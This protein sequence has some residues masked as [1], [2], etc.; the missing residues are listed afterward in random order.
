MATKVKQRRKVFST[1]HLGIRMTQ[2]IKERIRKRIKRSSTFQWLI[3]QRL[4][5]E[6]NGILRRAMTK[7]LLEWMWLDL[8][9]TM[10]SVRWVHGKQLVFCGCSQNLDDFYQL[11]NGTLAWEQWLAQHELGHDTAC[12]P[13]INAACVIC[14]TKNK[15]RCSVIT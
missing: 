13:Y 6:S 7:H 5:D 10:L 1:H 9:E 4:C 11:I 3:L 8:G 12:R 14:C 2:F 15:L